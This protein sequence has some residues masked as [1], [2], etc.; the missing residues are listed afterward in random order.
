MKYY[1]FIINNTN[2]HWVYCSVDERSSVFSFFRVFCGFL[3]EYDSIPIS[4]FSVLKNIIGV[5]PTEI[6]EGT[7][8]LAF[9]DALEAAKFPI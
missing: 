7:F 5:D 6:S 8:K 1:V 4:E 3:K 2:N 9:N